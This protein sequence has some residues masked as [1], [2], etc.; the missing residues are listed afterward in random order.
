MIRLRHGVAPAVGLAS[1][2][3][4]VQAANKVMAADPAGNNSPLLVLSVQRPAQ[5]V[6]YRTMNS[7]PTILASALALGAMLALW[8]TLVSSVRRHQG[9]LALLKTLGLRPRQV[10]AVISWQSTVVA[11]VGV[12]AGV[13]VGV[14]AGRW[15]WSRFARTID[16][17]PQ[18]AVPVLPVLLIALGALVLANAVALIPGQGPPGCRRPYSSEPSDH[19]EPRYIDMGVRRGRM[20]RFLLGGEFRAAFPWGSSPL[21]WSYDESS[22]RPPPAANRLRA[23]TPPSRRPGARAGR[24]VPAPHRRVRRGHGLD[25]AD[26]PRPITMASRSS[27][28]WAL[29][30]GDA[31][32]PR[33]PSRPEAPSG[34][35]AAPGSRGMDGM[36]PEANPMTR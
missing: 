35:A 20:P 4:V 13:P 30:D 23:P 12:A 17:V 5:I 24:S 31:A 33:C 21:R 26:V 14:V 34:C 19:R 10:A 1:L 6:N 16:A 11:L 15:L 28:S 22:S 3:R 18:P 27:S 25:G 9:D 2:H 32:W 8:L 29:L 36:D 7:T